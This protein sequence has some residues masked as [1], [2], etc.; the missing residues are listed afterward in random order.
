MRAL[1]GFALVLAAGGLSAA[2][3]KKDEKPDPKKLVGKWAVPGLKDTSLLEFTADGKVA[4]KLFQNLGGTY[5]LNGNTLTLK[6]KVGAGEEELALTVVKL[7]DAEL[8]T[9]DKDGKEETFERV[10]DKK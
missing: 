10:K 6:L 3:D 1:L 9:K 5:K 4:I 2:D 7:T 8:V